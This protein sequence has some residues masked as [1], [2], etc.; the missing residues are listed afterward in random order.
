[1]SMTDDGEPKPTSSSVCLYFDSIFLF[2]K[3]VTLELRV[4]EFNDDS[5]NESPSQSKE[6][7]P[8]VVSSTAFKGFVV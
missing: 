3:I 7:N 2:N 6:E 1:M 5:I 4:Q 8:V